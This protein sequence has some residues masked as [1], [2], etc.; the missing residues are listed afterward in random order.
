MVMVADADLAG[1]A[2]EVAVTVTV[3]PVGMAD[4][5]VY[6]TPLASALALEVPQAPGLPQVSDHVTKLF[7]EQMVHRRERFE[8]R[9]KQNFD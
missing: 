4:G 1:V 5:A 8:T 6:V 7:T 3:D 9:K 2:M